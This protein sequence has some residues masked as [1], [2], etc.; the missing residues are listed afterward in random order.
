ML[1]RTLAVALL[2]ITAGCGTFA[3]TSDPTPTVTPAPVTEV[4]TPTDT[5]T[6]IAPGVA[7]GGVR[8]VDRLAEAHLEALEGATYVW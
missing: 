4:K 2:A 3:T 8:N 5:P 1:W 6:G 7:G